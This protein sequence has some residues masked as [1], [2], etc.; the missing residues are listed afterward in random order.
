MSN[1]DVKFTV[2]AE[3]TGVEAALARVQESVSVAVDGMKEKLESLN[4]TFAKIQGAFLAFTAVL[5]GGEAFKEMIGSSVDLV[6]ESQ[7]LGRQFGISASDASVLKVA[8]GS[9]FVSQDTLSAGAAKITIAL[10]KNES[11]FTDLGVATRDQNGDFRS[12]M[13]IMQDTNA[14]LLEFKEGV[15]RNVEGTKI[16]GRAWQEISPTLRLTAEAMEEARG[17]A[18]ELGLIVGQESVAQTT[19]YRKAMNGV[20]ETLEGVGVV[21]GNALLPVLT[22]M[23]QWFSDV[24]PTVLNIFKASIVTVATVISEV[25]EIWVVEIDAIKG[26][27]GLLVASVMTGARVINRALHA[28]WEGVKTAWAEGTANVSAKSKAMTDEIQSDMAAATKSREDFFEH[29][30]GDQTVIPKKTGG[31]ASDGG[32]DRLKSQMAAMQAELAAERDHFEESQSLQG[33]FVEFSTAQEIDFWK[34]QLEIVTKGS[35]DA[36]RVQ[37]TIDKLQHEQRKTAHEA[38]L[39]DLKAQQSQ[40]KNNLEA[41]LALAVD[42][43][44]KISATEG[45]N[46]PNAK[47]AQGDVLAIDRELDAQ[48]LELAKINQA[49]MN[50][51]SLSGIDID[52]KSAQIKL[53]NHQ[54]TDQEMLAQERQFEAQRLQIKMD[55]LMAEQAL[56]EK[57][58]QENVKMLADLEA[59]KLTLVEQ[60][61]QKLVAI[62]L[63]SA[64]DYTKDWAGVFKSME[65]GFQS[66]L[67]K[68]ANGTASLGQTVKGLFVSIAQTVSGALEQMAAKQIATMLQ[69]AATGNMIRMKQILADAYAAGAGAYAAT[70]AIP[71]VGPELAPI[72]AAGAFAGTMAFGSSVSAE[73]GYD[74][75]ANINPIVQTHAKEMIL[76]REHA[77]TIRSLKNNGGGG[78]MSNTDHAS[79]AMAKNFQRQTSILKRQIQ[80]SASQFA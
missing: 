69:A 27:F 23:G 41:K 4:E 45:A 8:L 70:A 54:I 62:N 39:A 2:G 28:D 49:A 19:A 71:F 64:T 35:G 34:S 21:I 44:N 16:Y 60:Y 65:S 18:S 77:D 57:N 38:E 46:S 36:Q 56:A 6:K 79:R 75:G 9:V 76:P 13:D 55:G 25:K 31:E 50:N 74:I 32:D 22:S 80:R 17:K 51:L 33:H 72:A 61:N 59:Q 66:V 48:R 3:D 42:F 29:M 52:E 37:E 73:G 68:F 20:H 15:D 1:E 10:K 26:Y 11:A 24:G 43:A 30:A 67:A 63:K 12:T 14:R 40:Y 7:A 58:P 78:G 53:A 47:K 5:A